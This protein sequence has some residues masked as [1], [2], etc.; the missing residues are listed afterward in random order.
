MLRQIQEGDYDGVVIAYSCFEMIPLSTQTVLK[1]MDADVSRIKKAI[2]DLRTSRSYNLWNKNELEKEKSR[3]VK[4]THEFLDSINVAPADGVSFESLEINTLFLDEAHNYKNLPIKTKMKDLNGINTKGSAK[5]LDL[6]HKIRCV[7]N[8]N[9]GRGAVFATGTPLCNSI[10]DAYAMQ[11][12]LQYEDLREAHLDVFDNWVKTFATPEQLIEIDVDTSKYRMV[13][14]F[15]QFH[16]L[17]DLSR[18][19]SRVAVFY[20]VNNAEELP[21]LNGYTDEVIPKYPA[22][23]GYMK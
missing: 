14:K 21:E 18:M 4:L 13:R 23:C 1:N 2:N 22:L 15:V 19:F 20:A 16:N 3:I 12:Y 7:Q 8:A 17:P 6:L 9:G 10:S 5:C 11:I